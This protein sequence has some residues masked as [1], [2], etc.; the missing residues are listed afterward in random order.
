MRRL[1]KDQSKRD[2]IIYSVST[3][4]ADFNSVLLDE[5]TL[6]VVTCFR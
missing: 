4:V 5:G 6:E 2:P 3:Y 1:E